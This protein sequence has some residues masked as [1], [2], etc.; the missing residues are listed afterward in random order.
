LVENIILIDRSEDT[1]IITLNR[2]ERLNAQTRALQD[3]FNQALTEFEN[4]KKVKV[5]IITG[6]GDKAFSAGADIYEMIEK[7]DEVQARRKPLENWIY[8]LAACKKPT[9]A[10]VNGLA[11]GGGALMASLAD[12]RLGCERTSFKFM[13][14]SVG[15]VNSTWSLPFIVG[16]PLAKE[17][18]FTGR[19]VEAEEALRIGLV[20]R[21]FK[22][23][24]LMKGAL[25][26]AQSIAA[27]NPEAVQGMKDI[28][29]RGIGMSLQEMAVNESVTVFNVLKVPPPQESFKSFL[30]RKIQ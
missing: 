27:N 8:H 25:E 1:A 24:D 9:I 2:P 7:P 11:Y 17:L 10:A 6:S 22:S 18:L 16:L 26:M 13:S 12:I 4:D 15:R 14:A 30:E 5:I 29:T 20:N 28:M 3:K 23:N 21:L 19:V